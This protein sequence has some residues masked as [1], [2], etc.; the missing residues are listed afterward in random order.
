MDSFYL[1]F[2]HTHW[3]D[4]R[5]YSSQVVSVT[6]SSSLRSVQSRAA[7]FARPVS[8][9]QTRGTSRALVVASANPQVKLT[10]I[11]AIENN[12]VTDNS[13]F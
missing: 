10:L 2:G 6:S 9:K 4:I 13:W 12:T 3:I 1:H 11:S 5:H 8:Q 7:A